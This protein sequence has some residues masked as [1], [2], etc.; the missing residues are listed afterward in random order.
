MEISSLVIIGLVLGLIWLFLYGCK[1]ILDAEAYRILTNKIV[2]CIAKA[3]VEITGFKQ[4]ENRLEAVSQQIS[5]LATPRERAIL[6][7]INLR[8]LIQGLFTSV[9]IPLFWR[10]KG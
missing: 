2:A 1:Q 8:S 10:K 4:G 6:Q 7:K 9:F 3:E 5:N